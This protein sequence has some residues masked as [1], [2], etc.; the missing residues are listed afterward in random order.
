MITFWHLHLFKVKNG[1]TTVA[2]F[3]IF[4][5][6]TTIWMA[7]S[8]L[9]CMNSKCKS[10]V[11]PTVQ[12]FW[13]L[14]FERFILL[15]GKYISNAE[16]MFILFFCQSL[17]HQSPMYQRTNCKKNDSTGLWEGAQK[18]KLAPSIGPIMIQGWHLWNKSLIYNWGAEKKFAKYGV[19]DWCKTA[20]QQY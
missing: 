3:C 13:V 10:P 11:L 12:L 4:G 2:R 9:C 8:A 19:N 15:Q 1:N 18:C 20:R 6:V 17:L 14:Q 16:S 5:S 7:T